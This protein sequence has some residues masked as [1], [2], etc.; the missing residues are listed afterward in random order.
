MLEKILEKIG[1][2]EKEAKVYLAALELGQDSVQNIAKK[3]GVNRPTAYFILERLMELGLASTLESGRKTVFVAENPKELETLLE[4]EKQEMEARRSE[5]KESMNQFLAIYN[6][7]TGK[8]LVR[9]FEGADGLVVM[10]R[11]GLNMLKKNSE[12]LNITPI[13]LIEKYFPERRKV[14]LGDRVK[15]G[16]KSRTIYTHEGGEIPNYQNDKEL[17]EGVFIPRN[18][19]PLEA[20]LNIYPQ[21]GIKLYYFDPIKPYGVVIESKEL[22]KNMAMMFELAWAGAKLQAQK[23]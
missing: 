10:D 17:R 3:A 22:A 11:H 16:I 9:Y 8:P 15:L 23:R 12:I 1:L 5:L 19:F 2:S 7:K 21:W 18:K 14:S 4:R 13:D 6:A 20:T